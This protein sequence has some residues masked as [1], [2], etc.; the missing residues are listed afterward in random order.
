MVIVEAAHL[1]KTYFDAGRKLTVLKDVDV[2][3][4]KG[5]IVSIVGPSGAG[6]STLL[7]ILGGLDSPSEGSVI[8]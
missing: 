8:F 2:K 7:H 6:K 3:I 1:H 5:E 4:A